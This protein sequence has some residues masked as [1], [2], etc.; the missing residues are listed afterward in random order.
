MSDAL[1]ARLRGQGELERGSALST[2]VESCWAIVRATKR[3]TM[4][5]ATMPRT[6]PLGFWRAVMRPKST[7]STMV[8]PVRDL[9]RN[10]RT[11][12]YLAHYQEMAEGVLKSF[13]TAFLLHPGVPPEDFWRKCLGPIEKWAFASQTVHPGVARAAQEDV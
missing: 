3:R 2:S 11:A 1:P 4:S 6:P 13:L 12:S 9:V 5:P 7:T 8:S 10:A